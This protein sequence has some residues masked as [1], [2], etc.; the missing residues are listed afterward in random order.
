M[1]W[2]SAVSQP[3][4]VEVGVDDVVR[5]RYLVIAPDHTGGTQLEG[6]LVAG[7][8]VAAIPVHI[9]LVGPT[10]SVLLAVI[11]DRTIV[12]RFGTALATEWL[13]GMTTYTAIP[14]EPTRNDTRRVS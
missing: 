10:D 13:P 12:A 7:T 3:G 6:E 4:E 9:P 11:P 2:S 1:V 8:R 5:I 14:R